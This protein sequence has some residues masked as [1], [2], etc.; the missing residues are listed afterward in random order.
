LG[1][2]KFDNID[3]ILQK[4]CEIGVSTISLIHTEHTSI[5]NASLRAI[6]KLA[7][8]QKV[9]ESAAAQCW[10]TILPQVHIGKL[11]DFFIH[12]SAADLKLILNPQT[13]ASYNILSDANP[14]HNICVL[15]GPE[16]GF[17][18][19]ELIQASAQDFQALHLGPRILR[20]ET[21]C[22]CA[23]TML[24]AKFGDLLT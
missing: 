15:I 6:E 19:Q 21:A 1:I 9:L 3:L 17:S 20:T 13:Q 22:F 5:K 10:R 12:N 18:E 7:H 11:E 2:I 23:L 16:G 14:H 24:Q 8:W 4:A